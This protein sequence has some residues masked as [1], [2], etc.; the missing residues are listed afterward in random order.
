VILDSHRTVERNEGVF[1]I[2]IC[3]YLDR[4]RTHTELGSDDGSSG[5]RRRSHIVEGAD[6]HRRLPSSELPEGKFVEMLE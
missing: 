2:T 1:E 3:R 5:C 6:E 4:A